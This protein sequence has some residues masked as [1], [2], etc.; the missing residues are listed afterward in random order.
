MIPPQHIVISLEF[1]ARD[2]TSRTRPVPLRRP[3]NLIDS[4]LPKENMSTGGAGVTLEGSLWVQKVFL[5]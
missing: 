1:I 5:F 2:R 3:G 4:Q